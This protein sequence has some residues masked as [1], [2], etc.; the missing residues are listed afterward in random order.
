MTTPVQR[1]ALWPA[2]LL[3]AGTWILL[4]LVRAWSP[5][6]ITI[7]GQAAATP[8]ENIG[9]FALGCAALPLAL[10][11]LLRRSP[12]AS[13]RA[14]WVSL[15]VAVLARVMVQVGVGGYPHLVVASIGVV[16]A[17]TWLALALHRHATTAVPG[18]V[19]GIALSVVT[20]AALGTWGAV[21][22]TDAWGWSLLVAQVALVVVAAVLARGV[23]AGDGLPRP[24]GWLIWPGL[25]L[26][27][28]VVANAGRASATLSTLGL[29]MI[30]AGSVLAV[31]ATRTRVARWSSVLA[32]VVLV[33][34]VAAALLV[35]WNGQIRQ[36]VGLAHLVGMPALA[37]LLAAAGQPRR[38][39]GDASSGSPVPVAIGGV[40][41]VALLFGYYAGYDL[42]YRADALVI[43]VAAV[44]GV[45]GVIAARP[46]HPRPTQGWGPARVAA[47]GGLAVIAGVVAGLG[48]ATTIP[49][50]PTA[51]AGEGTVTVAAYNLR[52]GYGMDGRFRATEVAEVLAQAQV[53]LISEVDR[54][55]YLNGGQ[56]QLAILAQ[57]LDRD[58]WFG[59][60]AD[61]VWGDA[62]LIDAPR[63]TYAWHPLPDHGAVTG[64][65]AL[66]IRSDAEQITYVSTHLQP[67]GGGV[68]EQAA[69]LAT[70]VQALVD[71]GA[72]VVLGGDF[73]MVEGSEAYESIVATGLVDA[74]PGGALTSSS[75]DLTQ[76]IDYVFTTPDLIVLEVDVPSTQASDHLPVLVTLQTD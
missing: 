9:A 76:R 41:W 56:D 24:L 34:V 57:M 49:S 54:G 20:H 38:A 13:G 51:A 17:M 74:D 11:L 55:W 48:P 62:V 53:G 43:A 23:A 25:F 73:N 4:D 6:L 16:A 59:A 21:W 35:V 37:H 32:G 19:T 66:V 64:A 47:V 39:D 8:P 3:A 31:A 46:K 68:T 5:T 28:V 33:G 60:A 7:Y 40:V 30:A 22:R 58:P 65:Q 10:V 14:V 67:H 15:A 63:V 52:M 26:A 42:G 75:D 45:V 27:G 71:D 61:P 72:T 1:R 29:A 18:L 70:I 50:I 69:D 36:S 12:T 44:I 2:A